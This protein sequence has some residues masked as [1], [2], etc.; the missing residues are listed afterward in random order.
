MSTPKIS[1]I[2]VSYNQGQFI[3]QN[4]ESVLNQNYPNFE[5]IIVDGGST[6]ETLDILKSYPHL[7]WTSEPDRGQSHG[8]NKGFD[9]ASGDII[10]WLNSDDWYAPNIFSQIAASLKESPIILSRCAMT[11]K[12]GKVT[13]V[14]ENIE[15]S[16]FDLLKY[17][18]FYSMPTQ[19]AV[20][21]RRDL[22]ERHKRLDGE[23]LDESLEYCMDY[24]LLL[25]ITKEFPLTKRLPIITAH[26]RMWEENKTG[27]EMAAVYREMSRIY[28]KHANEYTGCEKFISFIIPVIDRVPANLEVTLQSIASQDMT[29]VQP[30]VVFVGTEKELE[31]KAKKTIRELGEKYRS[32]RFINGNSSSLL[33]CINKGIFNCSSPYFA[34]IEPGMNVQKDFARELI[35]F[36]LEDGLALGLCSIE[37][38]KLDAW[39]SERDGHKVFDVGKIFSPEP[40]SYSLVGRSIAFHELGGFSLK[41]EPSIANRDFILRLASR[42]WRTDVANKLT[43]Q[44]RGTAFFNGPSREEISSSLGLYTAQ[45]A[46]SWRDSTLHDPFFSMRQAHGFSITIPGN[47]IDEAEKLLS[48]V[49]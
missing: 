12:E 33:E 20:F 48:A 3:R 6:D 32:I 34:L 49:R 31:R 16:W 19:P 36:F 22:I 17:W 30:V 4:I 28:S 2:T 9:R 37:G 13:E 24:D 39:F 35:N 15:R 25:R 45:L 47:I 40:L 43:I 21:F 5:H 44:G 8:L 10:A 11:D 41:L 18:V 46:L 14:V 29:M 27:A 1:V 23:V 26:Y 7:N 38:I 42:G